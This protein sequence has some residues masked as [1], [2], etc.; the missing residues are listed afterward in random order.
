MYARMYKIKIYLI[1]KIRNS[2]RDIKQIYPF[3]LCYRCV[4][5]LKIVSKHYIK[6][7]QNSYSNFSD[8]LN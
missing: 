6:I 4:L 1:K 5:Y 7:M 8:F 3:H 2:D